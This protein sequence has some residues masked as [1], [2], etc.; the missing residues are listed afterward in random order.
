M[1]DPIYLDYNATSPLDPTVL[2]AMEPYLRDQFGN[3]SSDHVYGYRTRAAVQT[4]REQL[5][6]LL[7]AVPEEVIFTGGGSEANNLALKGVADALR[8]R[9]THLITSAVEHPSITQPLRFLE[10]QGYQVTTLAV[11]RE[12]RVDL[13][14]VAAALTDHTILV[15]I[16]H[17][18]NEVGT[19]Q[20]IRAIVDIAHERGVL[21]HVDA[22]QSVGKLPVTLD[23]LGADLLTV[24]GHKFAAP[25]GV[26]ALIV[27]RGVHL[28]PLIHGADHEGGRRAGTENVP[29]LVGLGAAAALAGRRLPQ[30]QERVGAL[31]DSLQRN[32]VE[33]VPSA[34]LNGH[35]VERLPNTLNLSFPGLDAAT[36]LA[37]VRDR[38]ACSTGSAC[39]AGQA[40]PSSVL[41]AMGR[42]EGLAAAALRLSL[43]WATTEQEVR[44][45]AVVITDAVHDLIQRT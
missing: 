12:G 32:I 8:D 28:E 19:V 38:V 4:A 1:T 41:L 39:H 3:P 29:S 35:P 22:A 11:D 26:G 43:G 40:A 44:R 9:G 21:V 14:R 7:G 45:A 25:K 6:A 5:A 24:A 16:M 34:V 2:E 36:L 10:R 20:P 42:D 37:R 13:A 18:N 17:A 31:R 15:S 30:Y 27:R 33:R 23:D